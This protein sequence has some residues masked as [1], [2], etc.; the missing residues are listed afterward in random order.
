MNGKV[1]EGSVTY[2]DLCLNLG[3]DC[4]L[5]FKVEEDM[6]APVFL[7]Y[8]LTNFYQ[9]HRRYLKS[10]SPSQLKGEV[11]TVSDAES[12]CDPVV[13]NKD[14]N[15]KKSWGGYDLDPEQVAN[16]CGLVAKSIFNGRRIYQRT[17]L[18]D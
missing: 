16:P 5:S 11:I 13:R 7:F 2:G 12:A 1:I 15:V 6:K 8:E 10:K 17:N 18:I 9:N 4:V 14:L 3:Q